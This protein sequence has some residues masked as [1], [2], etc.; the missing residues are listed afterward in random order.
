MKKYKIKQ[1]DAFTTKAFGWNPA[2]VLMDASWLTVTQM[3]NIAKEMNV[4]ETAFVLPSVDADL[5]I[6]WF[7]PL[8]E[9]KFCWHA[10]IATV[11][12]LAEENLY[13]MLWD[14][15][16]SLSVEWLIGIIKLQITKQDWAIDITLA[17]PEYNFE[18]VS[19]YKKDLLWLLW[20]AEDQSNRELWIW[21]DTSLNKVYIAVKSLE[22]LKNMQPNF[23]WLSNFWKQY[24]ISGYML[25]CLE[26]TFDAESHVHSRYF[27]PQIGINED[28]CTGSA[29][30]PLWGYLVGKWLIGIDWG[31]VDILSE[32][33]DIMWRKWRL[34]IRVT[35]NEEWKLSSR[36][37]AWAVTVLEGE[38]F[39]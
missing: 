8:A 23:V 18:N 10:T 32:Q 4:S 17:S 21:I 13:W 19:D 27:A 16:F 31:S 3:Q 14:W 36:L 28:P 7:S 2:W 25:F 33:W 20:L 35:K 6:R 12:A 22:I 5:K 9:V 11:H 15:D 29:Q 38:V 39:V 37:I 30:W 1:V 26:E 24:W 34:I